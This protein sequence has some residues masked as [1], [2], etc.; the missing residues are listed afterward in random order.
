MV[1]AIRVKLGE[2]ASFRGVSY[3]ALIPLSILAV[4]LHKEKVLV[5]YLEKEGWEK[6]WFSLKELEERGVIKLIKEGEG[7]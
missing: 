5:D 1:I 3:V 6:D 2:R 4:D 7:C